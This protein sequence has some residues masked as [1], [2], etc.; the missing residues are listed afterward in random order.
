MVVVLVLLANACVLLVNDN[1]NNGNNNRYRL[2]QYEV[3]DV[4]LLVLWVSVP[5]YVC[6]VEDMWV[7]Q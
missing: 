3:V 2:S 6:K 7:F 1:N 4:M 5:Q